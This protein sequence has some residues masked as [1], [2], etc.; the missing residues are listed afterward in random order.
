MDMRERYSQNRIS[1][2]TKHKTHFTG[3]FGYRAEK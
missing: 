2:E 1:T 3:G